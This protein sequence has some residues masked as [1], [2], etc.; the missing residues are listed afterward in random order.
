MESRDKENISIDTKLALFPEVNPNPIA[1]INSLG[2]ILYLNPAIKKIFPDID[3]LGMEHQFL[4]GLE[5]VFTV[6]EKSQRRTFSRVVKI[7]G[8]WYEQELVFVP[9]GKIIQIYAFDITESKL[10]EEKLKESEEKYR[11]LIESSNDAIFI[12]DINTGLII[13]VNK[14]AE[15]VL[16]IPRQEIIG[17]HFSK[18]HP[19]EDVIFHQKM[20]ERVVKEG[21]VTIF[22]DDFYLLHKSGRKIPVSL[23]TNIIDVGNKKLIQ[24]VFRDISQLRAVEAELRLEKDKIKRYL[25]ITAAIILVLEESGKISLINNTGAEILGVKPA[26]IIGKNWFDDFVPP[27]TRPELKLVFKRL[28]RGEVGLLGYF[29]NLIISK[30]GRERLIA[31]NNTIFKDEEKNMTMV[32]SSG[33]DITEARKI[34]DALVKSKDELEMRVQKR[35]SELAKTNVELHQEIEEHLKAEKEVSRLKRQIEFILGATKTGLDIIDSEYNMV[36]VDPEWQKTYGDPKGK[37]CYEYFMDRPQICDDCGVKKAL[38]TKRLVIAEEILAKENNRP[39]QITTIPFQDELGKWFVAE[40]NVDISER[41]KAEEAL[42]KSEEQYRSLVDNVNIGIYRNTPGPKGKFL[43]ANPAIVKMFGYDSIE[44]FLTVSVSD[45]YWEPQERS[46]FIQEITKNGLVRN[47]ELY[48]KRKNGQSLWGSVTAK[49]KFDINKNIEWIDGV[50]EDITERKKI[51]EELRK[52]EEIHRA[53]ID[54][55]GIGVAL[56][57]PEMKV[58]TMNKQMREWNPAVEISKNPICYQ[59]FN[60]PPRQEICS[61]CPTCKTLEDGQIHESVTETPT[62]GKILNF[63]IISSPVR[64]QSGKVIAAVEMVEDITEKKRM[65]DAL[66]ESQAH[67]EKIVQTITDYIYTVYVVDGKAV[68]TVYGDACLA[69]TGYSAEEFQKDPYLWINM[70]YPQDRPLVL[71]QAESLL[72]DGRVDA[73]EHRIIRKNKQLR[74]VRNTPVVHFDKAGNFMSYDGVIQDITDRKEAQAQQARAETLSSIIEGVPDSIVVIDL[75]GKVKK[76]NKSLVDTFCFG[77]K[78]LNNPLTDLFIEKEK[79]KITKKIKECIQKD[80]VDNF[81]TVAIGADNKEISILIKFS[82]LKNTKGETEFL[83]GIMTDITERKQLEGLKDEFINTLSHEL[84][85]PLSAMKEG[86]TIVLSG[87]AGKINKKQQNCLHTAN[88]NIDRLNRMIG[89]ILDYQRMD[90]GLSKLELK[91]NDINKLVKEVKVSMDALASEKKLKINLELGINLLEFQFDHDR[92]TQVLVNLVS[93]AIK[94]TEK[95]K[96]TIKTEHEGNNII[97]S[98]KDTGAGIKKESVEKLFATFSQIISG[99]LK[100]EGAGLGLVISKK[101]VEQ[102]NGKIWC[103]SEFGKGSRFCF[104]L[105]ILKE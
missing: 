66:N 59:A 96:I 6:F 40:I 5:L 43:Q 99:K 67:F 20:F 81:D 32:L 49:A 34:Q 45:L 28:V 105:P 68:K 53:V 31:W 82:P 70:V 77:E 26:E 8:T 2:N 52:S 24:G 38:E 84:R 94:F 62:E 42:R 80:K 22:D 78:C 95:G 92:I 97:V 79:Q 55:I 65:Q 33:I 57:S 11:N 15:E 13:D 87:M 76:F 90:Y 7:D 4:A 27:K 17:L 103:E 9:E 98:V 93:N 14:E 91:K 35:T 18:L 101:I 21:R 39:V 73:I 72:K 58:L 36:Y 85:T 86:V 1:E 75:D 104:S 89:N 25:D 54:N 37:K 46:A 23:S 74:W 3:K 48:L 63:R 51:E 61:Y 50:I 44:D 16:G 88:R 100:R 69:V 83:I 29:E 47:K 30:D 41:K 64:D 60:N 56:I 102:H 12:A 71:S 10:V 19:P